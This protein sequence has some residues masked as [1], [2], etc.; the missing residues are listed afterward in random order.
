MEMDGAATTMAEDIF[1]PSYTRHGRVRVALALFLAKA[2]TVGVA[3]VAI[4]SA[5]HVLRSRIAQGASTSAAAA[6]NVLGAQV[7]SLICTLLAA[8]CASPATRRAPTI[9]V[10]CGEHVWQFGGIILYGT[11]NIL[12]STDFQRSR[13]ES[14]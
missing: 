2:V 9:Q 13:Y 5:A 1:A 12:F 11:V 8:L 4:P 14:R 10:V 7:I 6:R 3:I